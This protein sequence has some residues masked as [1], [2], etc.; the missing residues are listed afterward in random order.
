MKTITPNKRQKVI[1]MLKSK[2]SLKETLTT[3][4]IKLSTL[5]NTRKTIKSFDLKLNEI[6]RKDLNKNERDT[7][8]SL[9]KVG[10]DLM[11]ILKSLDIPYQYHL[12]TINK[13]K[14][15]SRQIEK[16]KRIFELQQQTYLIKTLKKFNGDIKKSLSHTNISR[17]TYYKW[18][19][20]EEDFNIRLFP[21]KNIKIKVIPTRLVPNDLIF[22]KLEKGVLY[23]GKEVVG[24][25]CQKC[26]KIKPIRHFYV[27]NKD[28]KTKSTPICI[29]CVSI[30]EVK[31]KRERHGVLRNDKIVKRINSNSNTTH[32]RCTKCDKIKH[33]KEFD[34]LYL[35]IHVCNKC[36]KF[37]PN[38]NPN[39]TGELYKGEIVR[40]FDKNNF[41][42]HKRCSKCEDKRP[43]K[44]FTK[45]NNN[46]LDGRGIVCVTCR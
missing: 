45:N 42:S 26:R 33:L 24:R 20:N 27:N 3:L 6:T 36:F 43:L 14:T 17:S 19:N 8:I 15:Y 1:K 2:F 11:E 30:N 35:G 25:F 34:K 37:K 9:L 28:I 41:V 46:R 21:Y 5:N 44:D 29:D 10:K 31:R 22:T 38:F 16:S 39:R 4:N 12:Y 18:R 7:I 32:R 23:D 40:W 13:N